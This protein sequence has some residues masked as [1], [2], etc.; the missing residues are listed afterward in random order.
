MWSRP[1]RSYAPRNAGY[2][3]A[4]PE[5]GLS[6]ERALVTTYPLRQDDGGADGELTLSLAPEYTAGPKVHDISGQA[7]GENQ[8]FELTPDAVLTSLLVAR[9]GLVL[10]AGAAEDGKDYTATAAAIHFHS[11][12]GLGA[13]VLAIYIDTPPEGA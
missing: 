12:P 7:D 1:A 2:V 13:N 9:D 11:P 5:A 6:G 10:A 8:D 4:A 3:T